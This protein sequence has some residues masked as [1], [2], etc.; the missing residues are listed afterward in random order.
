MCSRPVRKGSSAASWR[1]APIVARTA[2]PSCTMSW[3]A[4]HA[5]PAVGGSRGGSMCTVGDFPPPFGP[6]KPYT[7]PGSTRRSMPSTARG[8]FLNSRT[9]PSVWIAASATPPDYAALRR[10]GGLSGELRQVL[11][12]THSVHAASTR[13]ELV[14]HLLARDLAAEVDHAVLGVDRDVALGERVV[15]EH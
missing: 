3:P 8:P 6:R 15:T 13:R 14:N 9:S 4:T 12:G 5:R 1:A 11:D 7:S 10:A 2:A